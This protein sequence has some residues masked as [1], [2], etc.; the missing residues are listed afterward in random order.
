MLWLWLCGLKG[1]WRRGD[2]GVCEESSF[3]N[4]DVQLRSWG[5][6]RSCLAYRLP[7]FS[8]VLWKEGTPTT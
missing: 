1:G 8:L 7:S 5:S 6:N 2:Q 4:H 3:K